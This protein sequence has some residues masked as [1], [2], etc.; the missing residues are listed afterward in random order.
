[1]KLCGTGTSN[2]QD[3]NVQHY[4]ATTLFFK[5]ILKNKQRGSGGIASLVEHRTGT[6]PTQVQ[7]P[8]A[9]RDFS[10]RVNFQ[11]RLSYGVCT[12]PCA[13]ACINICVHFKDPGVRVRVWWVMETLKHP[14]CSI[15]WVS[16]LCCSRLSTGKSNSNFPMGEIPWGEYSCKK[17][18]V[19]FHSKL[20][21]TGLQRESGSM[22]DRRKPGEELRKGK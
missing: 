21:S 12:P 9:A 11:R 15:G 2:S 17:P 20:Q 5:I 8:G 14:A 16:R 19:K 18:K 10:P 7:L 4:S 1:M 13:I 3:I 22:V 6:L